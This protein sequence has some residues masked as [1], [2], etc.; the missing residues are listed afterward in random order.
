MR[1][2]RPT[3]AADRPGGGRRC[4]RA[5]RGGRDG[6]QGRRWPPSRRTCATSSCPPARA[7]AASGAELFARKMRHTMRSETL[8][9]ERILAAAERE[10]D[11]RPGRDGPARPRAVAGVAPGAADARRRGR[12]SSVAC[13]TR[14]PPSTRRPTTCSTSAARRTPGSRRSAREHDLIGLADEP[15][16]IRWTP[17]FLRAF[18]GAMLDLAGPARQ[19]PEGVLRDHPDARRLDA[20]SSASRTCARTTT[21]C[22][23]C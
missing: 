15:L 5:W 16:E 12:A 22:S 18:G 13:S 14:S 23:G 6:A 17:V 9:P 8:T 1:S 2:R 4:S 19:G 21:G 11:G 3:A 20:T 10:F 7:R